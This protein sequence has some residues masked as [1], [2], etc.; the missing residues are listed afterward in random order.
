V[1]NPAL[2]PIEG[3]DRVTRGGEWEPIKIRRGNLAY[4]PNSTQRAS[5]LARP[6]PHSYQRAIGPQNRVNNLK[7]QRKVRISAS[8]ATNEPMATNTA[9][10]PFSLS[11]THSIKNLMCMTKNTR[12]KNDKKTRKLKPLISQLKNKTDFLTQSNL[13]GTK[14]ILIGNTGKTKTEGGTQSF[15]S[16][17]N[18]LR[19]DGRAA[20]A[21]KQKQNW[22]TDLGAHIGD[23]KIQLEWNCAG[24]AFTARVGTKTYGKSLA[25]WKNR[26][27]P[28]SDSEKW[29]V[30]CGIETGQALLLAKNNSRDLIFRWEGI[31]SI[32]TGETFTA[33][34]QPSKDVAS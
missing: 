9:Q 20:T 3:P 25:T 10:Q 18:I 21:A 33:W 22:K 11:H 16:R 34:L 19:E 5:L 32:W 13:A 29:S 23:N 12:W 17:W 31:S 14:W 26:P 15:S 4:V 27:G 8:K 30:G 28:I 2:I 24:D 6:R 1:T 7:S